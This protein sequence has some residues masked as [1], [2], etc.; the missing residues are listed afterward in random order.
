MAQAMADTSTSRT[1]PLRHTNR[2]VAASA[3]SAASALPP[4]P[5]T[6]P[7]DPNRE[8]LAAPD[9]LGRVGS[10]ECLPLLRLGIAPQQRI[11]ARRGDE[12]PKRGS[13]LER[14]V[15]LQFA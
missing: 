8:T 14:S 1:T 11:G 10:V 6:E 7:S 12:T 5:V 9:W 3:F 13:A 15:V 4:P 2:I